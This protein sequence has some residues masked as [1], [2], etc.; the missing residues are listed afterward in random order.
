MVPA[1]HELG[2][3]FRVPRRL[4]PAP[5]RVP[6]VGLLIR[7]CS[8]V[9][10]GGECGGGLEQERRVP[11]HERHVVRVVDDTQHAPLVLRVVEGVRNATVCKRQSG[12]C[13]LAMVTI[14]LQYLDF[15][16]KL[17]PA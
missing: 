7:V 11:F 13:M 9:E 14:R 1:A 10:Q 12:K 15:V 3:D 16:L 17:S 5:L 8:D 6:H 4:L 2:R